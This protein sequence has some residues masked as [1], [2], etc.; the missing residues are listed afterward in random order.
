MDENNNVI[1]FP[2]D[3]KNSPPQT[4]DDIKMFVSEIR[5]G[6]INI[7]MDD[8][9]PFIFIALSETVGSDVTESKNAKD[10]A[11]VIDSIKSLLLKCSSKHHELQDFCE[12]VYDLKKSKSSDTLLATSNYELINFKTDNEEIE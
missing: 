9:I 5:E 10:C 2:K 1:L 6:H 12:K 4:L 8:F 3:K 11:L 7:I